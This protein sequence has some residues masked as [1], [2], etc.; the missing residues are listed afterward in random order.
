M[1]GDGHLI[2]SAGTSAWHEGEPPDGR[3]TYHASL[4]GYSLSGASRA[5]RESDFEDYD[6]ILAMDVR[7]QFD[8]IKMCP[9]SESES[10]IKLLTDF[11]KIHEQ[12]KV[13]QGV[14]DPYHKGEEGF[15]IVLDIIEDACHELVKKIK[16]NVESKEI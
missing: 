7:N 8:L 5:V 2:D 13:N 12:D 10:K 1:L 9:D 11:C 16:S 15:G 6:L 4:R 14:P 3:S